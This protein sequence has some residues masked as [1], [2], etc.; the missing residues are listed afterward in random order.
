VQSF[1]QLETIKTRSILQQCL[2]GISASD[3]FWTLEVNGRWTLSYSGKIE[4]N[5]QAGFQRTTYRMY[6]ISTIPQQSP[7]KVEN[8]N[9]RMCWLNACY[10]CKSQSVTRQVK[11]SDH[12]PPSLAILFKSAWLKI[13]ACSIRGRHSVT[14][15]PRLLRTFSNASRITLFARSPI[16]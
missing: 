4:D 1:E 6:F 11:T 15:P 10:D 2:V 14:F 16:Q 3:S 8:E 13:C 7:R 9:L 5:V 12:L